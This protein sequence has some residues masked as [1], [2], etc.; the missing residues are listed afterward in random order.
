MSSEIP[1]VLEVQREIFVHSV[2]ESAVNLRAGRRLINCSA[3]AIS[4]PNGIE[5]AP[6]DLARLQRLASTRPRAVMRW[7]PRERAIRSS[8][9][10]VLIVSTP[11]TVLFDTALPAASGDDLDAA[12]GE[13]VAHLERTRARTG[14]GE[15]WTALTHDPDLVGAAESLI[16]G[17]ADE[18]V[19]HWV[20]R[21][22]GLTPSGDDVLVGMV[23]ALWFAGVVD[24]ARLGPLR[25]VIEG[26]GGSLTTDVSAEYLRYACRGMV[27]GPVRDLLVFLDR[28][29][30]TAVLDAVDRLSSF[31]HTS[32]TDCVLGVVVALVSAAVYGDRSATARP[33]PTGEGEG[34]GD[35]GHRGQ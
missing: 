2:F 10:A 33:R 9:G 16:G 4:I 3:A 14:L 17:R 34:G 13:L 8:T 32:G 23:A 5:M 29:D 24:R 18:A 27:T 22:P 30:T 6:S 31:G 7:D 20:G 1:R 25:A 15:D 35:D 21:G 28:S 26:A 19:I 11:A 12:A